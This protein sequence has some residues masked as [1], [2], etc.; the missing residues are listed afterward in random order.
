MIFTGQLV[1]DWPFVLGCDVSGIVVKTGS[2]AVG[3]LGPL[4]VGDA[5]CGCTRLGSKGYGSCE[6]Y[7]L[8]DTGL[9]LPK[10]DNIDFA[11]AATVGVGF[12]TACLGVFN[13]L[14]IEV[15][16]DVSNLPD[17]GGEWVLVFG[18]SSSVG[19]SA[20]QVC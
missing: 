16:K 6:E 8:M 19:K 4:K 10:P 14:G 7:L 13:G 11:Q 3:P 15:P 12:L 17:H 9:T 2:N 1:V 18:G 5:V 20:V